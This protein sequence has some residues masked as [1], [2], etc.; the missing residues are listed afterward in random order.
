MTTD[1]L[2]DMTSMSAEIVMPYTL[3]A[4]KAVGTFLAELADRRILGSQ[5]SSCATVRVPAQDFCGDCGAETAD[6]QH[7]SGVGDLDSWT[8][9]DQGVLAL[10]RL[11]GADVP[12]LHRI[13]GAEPEQLEPGLRVSAVWAD[14]P[15][16]HVLDLAGFTPTPDAPRGEATPAT[17]VNDA[18]P[19]Q[20]Y[21]MRLEYEH[22]YGHYYGTLFDG[23]ANGR[24]IR[25]VQCPSCESVLVPPRAM[26][27]KCYVPTQQWVDLP[28]TGVVQGCSVVHIEFVGQRVPPP[29]VYAE[30]I[31]DGAATRLIHTVGGLTAEEA[32]A[33]GVRP[34]ARVRA[35]W[36]DRR[37]GGLSDIDYFVVEG[38]EGHL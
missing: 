25:G 22:A 11:D 12:F 18:I 4:G 29:Y 10:V 14:E 16:G 23:I 34:G 37:T 15:R 31:L 13:V 36:S 8:V 38:A 9:T 19:Q 5:C 28:D 33:G 3:T 6:F 21:T 32:R 35:V 1:A 20:D 30:I 17:A 26:C 2:T 7:L 24:H 27:E